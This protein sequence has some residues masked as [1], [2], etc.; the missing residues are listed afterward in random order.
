MIN[1]RYDLSET[2]TVAAAYK[3]QDASAV[4]APAVA[5][6]LLWD[7]VSDGAAKWF[8]HAHG[9]KGE[10][11]GEKEEEKEKEE[12]EEKE[13]E[14]E[15]EE[16]DREQRQQ[17]QDK[18]EREEHREQRGPRETR[19]ELALMR[20]LVP[21]L[22]LPLLAR[23]VRGV[24]SALAMQ[25][26]DVSG[27]GAA[28]IFFVCAGAL[29]VRW[30][31]GRR[32]VATAGNVLGVDTAVEELVAQGIIGTGG[33]GGGWGGGGGGG[34][35]GEGGE[36]GGGGKGGKGG[37]GGG[38]RGRGRAR[39]GGGKGGKRRPRRWSAVCTRA[40]GSSGSGSG[41]GDDDD[42]DQEAHV[43]V[44]LR[45]HLEELVL[46]QRRSEVRGGLAELLEHVRRRVE[47]DIYPSRM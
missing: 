16:K 3:S 2:A 25:N 8:A 11:E 1:Y 23:T 9:G 32:R 41:D 44:I 13:K 43:L 4:A 31:D 26:D 30:D 33:G 38:R 46:G 20:S 15:E 21:L 28:F 6:E 19:E 34:G 27:P 45:G 29:D 24:G 5:V 39:R 42:E 7:D 10:E 47:A 40:E 22:R 36:G 14:E 18:R 17:E 37:G 35:G 12:E